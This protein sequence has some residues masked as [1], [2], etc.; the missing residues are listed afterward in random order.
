MLAPRGFFGTQPLRL[1]WLGI[2]RRW[3][4]APGL[5]ARDVAHL[6]L[7]SV[8]VYFFAGWFRG[9]VPEPHPEWPVAIWREDTRQTVVMDLEEYLKG[10]VAAEMP[11]T[12]HPE[13][14]KAQAVA[15]RTYALYIIARRQGVPGHPEAALST[16]YRVDQAWIP[17]TSL[18]KR[19]GF[20][21]YYWR[22]RRVSRA[23]DD[24]RGTVLTYDGEPI[25]A[26][27]HSD[28]GGATEDSENYWTAF[29]AYLRSV[30]DPVPADSPYSETKV[31]LPRSKV[32]N[33]V[34]S[35]REAVIPV[36]SGVLSVSAGGDRAVEVLER[37]PSGRV[38]Y[39]RVGGKTI[40]GR[41]LR[42]V[43]GLRSMWFYVTEEG[44]NLQFVVRGNGHGVGMSQ[45]GADAFARQGASFQEILQHYYTGVQLTRR[46]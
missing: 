22:W 16:D 26:A 14:L 4:L 45:Y 12:F 11:A 28:S 38:R 25:L 18:R 30:P 34:R 32:L 7:A 6:I 5:G 46:Y 27:F 3:R 21:E 2:R 13:A 42:E 40:T 23:V 15:S 31:A 20:L 1:W 9:P 10:V 36:G 19:Y 41:A 44:D 37:F 29:V 17:E 39:V 35:V 33:T 24:T 8:A 43:L